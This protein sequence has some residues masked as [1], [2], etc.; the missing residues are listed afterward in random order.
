[1]VQVV[2]VGCVRGLGGVSC[3]SSVEAV[4]VALEDALAHRRRRARRGRSN[5]QRSTTALAAG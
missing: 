1:M 2:L 4:E 5:A 3:G